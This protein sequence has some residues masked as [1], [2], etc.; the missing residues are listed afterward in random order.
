VPQPTPAAG[1]AKVKTAAA[2]TVSVVGNGP[3]VLLIPGLSC[4]GSV[5]N[6]TM[7]HLKGR[8]QCHVV[9]LAGYAGAPP[10]AAGPFLPYVHD[11]IVAYVKAKG[12]RQPAIVGHRLG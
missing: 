5:W 3:P 2:F 4:D 7:E 11:Q 12:L 1:T 9:S 10:M 8:F 6:A